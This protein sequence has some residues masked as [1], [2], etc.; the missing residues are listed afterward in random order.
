MKRFEIFLHQNALAGFEKSWTQSTYL[1]TI[2]KDGQSSGQIQS[3]GLCSV[4]TILLVLSF[5]LL[6]LLSVNVQQ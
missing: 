1:G 5:F 6:L 3:L 2:Y 4:N